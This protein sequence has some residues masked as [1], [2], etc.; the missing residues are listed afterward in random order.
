MFFSDHGAPGLVAFPNE[1][2][3][4]DQLNSAFENM[5]T[6]NMYK[7]LVFYLETCESGSMFANH[8]KDNL[9]IYAVT[10]ANPSESSW[11]TYCYPSD[12][13][14]GKHMGTCLGDLFSVNWM[15]NADAVAPNS[16]SLEE[17]F[18]LLVKET[19]KSHVMRY[20]TLSFTNE[21]I[22][23]FEGDLDASEEKFLDRIFG[24][25]LKNKSRPHLNPDRHSSTV[26]SRDAKLHHLY[27]KVS[28][29]GNHKAHIDLSTELN[30]R[31]RVDEVFAEFKGHLLGAEQY[32]APQN[33]ECLR[34]LVNTYKQSCGPLEDYS[35][36]YVKYFV[37][38]CETLSDSTDFEPSIQKLL[39]ACSHWSCIVLPW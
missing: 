38:E 2:L 27:A 1:E 16:E 25:E 6:N 19:D 5:Y 4:A 11:G 21:A 14:N 30:H 17:Q 24:R 12:M 9:N 28:E 35:L 26:S 22:G 15:E 23:E 39:N 29:N 37:Q 20:G 33:F 8:L 31:M 36:K 10:A 18:T 3:Y 13:V 7:Q 34:A 32:Y